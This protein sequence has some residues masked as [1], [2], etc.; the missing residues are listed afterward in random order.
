MNEHQLVPHIRF[1]GFEEEWEE[2]KISNISLVSIG[3]T[4]PTNKKEYYSEKGISWVTP[5]NI[6]NDGRIIDE[7]HLS[8]EGAKIAR[9]VPRG[10]ILITS[11]ASIGKNALVKE[12]TAFNQQINAVT[13]IDD[14]DSYFIYTLSIGLSKKMKTIAASGIMQIVNKKDFSK[15]KV[16]FP[17]F[18]EQQKIGNLFAKLDQLL[19]LEQQKLDQLGL[20]KKALLQ[21]L[22][23]ARGAKIPALR[24]QG[25]EDEWEEKQIK[26]IL[27]YERPDKYIVDSDKYLNKGTPVLTANK[28]FVLGY[29]NETNIY[30]KTLPVIIFDDFT[31]DNKLV[32]F[33]FMIKSS[34]IKILTPNGFSDIYFDYNLIKVTTFIKEGH[35]R[36]YISIVQNKK[37]EVPIKLEQQKIGA[38]LTHFDH[39]IELE[40]Q[41]LAKMKQVK[42]ALLQNMFVE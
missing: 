9:I 33:P 39:L 14:F 8:K 12:N 37:I 34:A 42:K 41:K 24:F 19:E 5:S 36:H 4:P 13:P 30:K 2:D 29:T 16:K 22:F 3:N 35:A 28:T 20:L 31:L 38:F 7:R 21:D 1:W 23:P 17:S 27:N 6:S 11:I 18:T 32:N 10:S 26:D 40:Q 15:M 25:F